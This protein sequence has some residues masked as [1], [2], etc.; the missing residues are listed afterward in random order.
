MRYLIIVLVGVFFTG[1]GNASEPTNVRTEQTSEE[2]DV[3]QKSDVN[4]EGHSPKTH[5]RVLAEDAKSKIPEHLVKLPIQ[6][7]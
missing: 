6:T 1:C 7:N 5:I 2:K 4:I 3:V